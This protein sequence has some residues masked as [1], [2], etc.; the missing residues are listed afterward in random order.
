MT[1][2][3]NQAVYY[4]NALWRRRW[5]AL[6]MSMV[7]MSLGWIG[8]ASLPNQYESSARIY[9]DTANVLG[10]LLKGVA[11]END[12]NRQVAVMRQTILSRPNL[13]QI[14]RMTDLDVTIT[15][16]QELEALI[17]RLGSKISVKADRENLFA[18]SYSDENPRLARDVV[19]AVTT[20]F[21]ENNLGENRAD[22][23]SAQSFLNR[24][25]AEYEKKL[26][27]AE[28]DLARFK[29]ANGVFLPGQTGIQ[30]ALEEARAALAATRAAI[31]DAEARKATLER[32]LAVTPQVIG[33]A[34]AG[35]GPPSS[36]MARLMQTRAAL[37]E[38]LSRYTEQHPDV[39]TLRRRVAALEEELAAEQRAFG[40][41]GPS[42]GGG[43][44]PNPVYSDLR[45]E[46]VRERSN[47]EALKEQVTRQ[48]A[49]VADLEK[50]LFLV[51]EIEAQLKR[52]TRDYDVIRANYE[53]LLSR[54]ESAR[55]SSDREQEGSRVNFRIIEAAQIPL[56]PSGPPRLLL[57]IA[58]FFL[59]LGAGAGLAWLLA[60]SRV[61]YG[62]VDHLRRDFDVP[63]F[64]TVSDVGMVMNRQRQRL[65]LLGFLVMGGASVMVFA[66]LL[67][68]EAQF[69]LQKTLWLVAALCLPLLAVGGI[70][71]TVRLA[72]MRLPERFRI[73]GR[74]GDAVFGTQ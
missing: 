3:L 34:Q 27:T 38:L 52:L 51:P 5:I 57:T 12:V 65:E 68:I 74:I 45:I 63:I 37:E 6:G 59:S 30:T 24:Q 73:G 31:I 35:S 53:T 8:V 41:A 39:Q 1:E 7:V 42:A 56:I 40:G 23:D 22:I 9:V 61:T 55:I 15:S 33:E 13:E 69:G 64:G 21:V 18:I 66:L 62:S 67:V 58:V 43:G 47:L 46:L 60:L 28:R 17:E 10:P 11:V 72:G 70:V 44:V 16:P 48:E 36:A 25:I 20:L 2:L 71:L 4:L 19:Q 50:K 14:A 26:D 29:Q 32:E 54:R 49:A